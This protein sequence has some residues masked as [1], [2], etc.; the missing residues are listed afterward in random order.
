MGFRVGA[1][2]PRWQI[3]KPSMTSS[4]S[5]HLTGRKVRQDNEERRLLPER[6]S[7]CFT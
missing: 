4:Y 1:K 5:R 7:A 6:V 3:A 2:P